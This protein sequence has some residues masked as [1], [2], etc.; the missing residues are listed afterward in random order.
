MLF[1]LQLLLFN[2]QVVSDSL[3][4]MDCSTP[5]LPV[6]YH[7]PEFAQVHVHGPI[8]LDLTATDRL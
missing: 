1:G 4:P 6:P 5:S 2:H 7:L 3:H 8:I